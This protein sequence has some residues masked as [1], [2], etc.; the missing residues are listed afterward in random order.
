M[1][2]NFKPCISLK[3]LMNFCCVCI[4]DKRGQEHSG[5]E[6]YSN[7]VSVFDTGQF[8]INTCKLQGTVTVVF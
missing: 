2:K 4:G 1:M 3:I 5:E 6:V 7:K 8:K